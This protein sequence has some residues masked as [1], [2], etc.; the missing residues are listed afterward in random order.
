MNKIG[1]L[2]IMVAIVNFEMACT[3]SAP[4]EMIS[5]ATIEGSTS[6]NTQALVLSQTALTKTNDEAA[7]PIMADTPIGFNFYNEQE[8]AILFLSD[9]VDQQ[10]TLEI[11]NT[12]NT[13][14]TLK[15]L[16]EKISATNHH[17]EL[18]FR[19]GT[20]NET[21]IKL[22]DSADYEMGTNIDSDGSISLYFKSKAALTMQAGEK[23]KIRLFNVRGD[24]RGGVRSTRVM[25]KYQNLLRAGDSK[26]FSG[27]IQSKL[28][29][30]DIRGRK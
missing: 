11:S 26:P 23:I 1:L 14:T 3:N 22:D 19:P 30:Q 10:M 15:K 28:S 29:L 25:L 16:T 8:E 9:Y 27:N 13:A 17:F 7:K 6:G 2:L 24:Q 12:S 18:V 4:E 21:A 20:I 5:A